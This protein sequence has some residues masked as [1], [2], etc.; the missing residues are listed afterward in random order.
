MVEV[1]HPTY[2]A[3]KREGIEVTMDEA[4]CHVVTQRIDIELSK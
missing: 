4:K 3:V 1:T 2:A